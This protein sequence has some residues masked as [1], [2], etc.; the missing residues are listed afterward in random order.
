MIYLFWVNKMNVKIM[1]PYGFCAGVEYVL[2]TIEQ[3][4]KDHK[5][6]NIYCIGQIVHNIGVNEYI[7]K[8]GVVVL[9]GDKELIVEK[10]EKGI[11][12]FSAHGT[13]QSI[14]N[15]AKEKGL[16]VYDAVCP[17]VKKEM[18]D[19]CEY[20]YEGYE[21]IFVGVKGHDEA[22]AVLSISNKIH[23]ITSAEDISKTSITT[24]KIVIVNQTTLSVDSLKCL[25][26][27]ILEI[28]PT[29][30]ISEEICNSSKIR[31][32]NLK[33]EAGDFD[34]IVVVG[35]QHSNNTI[36]L[37]NEAKKLKK[38]V[39]LCS[40]NDEMDLEKLRLFNNALVVSGA[41]VSKKRV[42]EIA[43]L[44]KK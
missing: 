11:V 37:F 23:L 44:L 8:Q 40:T 35:D 30:I 18:K 32:R 4:I 36:T 31:Q 20:L 24:D 17:F 7:K 21:I 38:N 6:E 26:K 14:I 42:E 34:L 16:I 10:I 25:H 29:A 5:G 33:R 1:K 39:I 22:N 19:I 27:K 41:S 9:E 28:Y 15:R 43:L 2:R 13:S 3:V 12:I